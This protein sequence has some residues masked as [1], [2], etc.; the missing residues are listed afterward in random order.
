MEKIIK[1]SCQNAKKKKSNKMLLYN[2]ADFTIAKVN[3]SESTNRS[4]VSAQMNSKYRCA[5][6]I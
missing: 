3:S 4:C 2:R 6:G 5:S 1:K